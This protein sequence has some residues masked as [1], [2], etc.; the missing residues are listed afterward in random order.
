VEI[1]QIAQE[2]IRGIFHYIRDTLL[3][4]DTA[5]EQ[6]GRIRDA[7]LSLESMPDR[8]ALLSDEYL[9]SKGI[10]RILVGNYVVFFLIN[11]REQAVRVIR[12]LYGRRDW[13]NIL[14]E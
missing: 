11:H 1:S 4:P 6:V 14:R 9:A 2:D 8:H 12:V 13:A 7:I 10:R 3:V 5:Y